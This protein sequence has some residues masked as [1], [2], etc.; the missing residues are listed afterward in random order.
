M[1]NRRHFDLAKLDKVTASNDQKIL[2]A[3]GLNPD[4]Y[5]DIQCACPVH[6]GDNPTGF[7]YDSRIKRW[8]C[9]T[10]KCHEKKEY[11]TGIIGLIRGVR[12]CGFMQAVNWLCDLLGCEIENINE[13]DL[14]TSNYINRRKGN[15]KQKETKIYDKSLLS[16]LNHN[17]DYFLQK[18]FKLE[19]LDHFHCFYCGNKEKALYGRACFPIFNINDDLVGFCGRQT[20]ILANDNSITHYTVKWKYVCDISNHLFNLNNLDAN[21]KTI[22]LVEGIPDVMRL[23]EAGIKNV[24]SSFSCH[25]TLEQRK[26]LI[27][28]GVRNIILLLDPDKAGKEA[29]E[30]LIK[31]NSM[32]F[33]IFDLR[34]LLSDDPGDSTV[35][36]LQE[37]L[38]LEISKIIEQDRMK[39]ETN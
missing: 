19:T 12:K 32:F 14:E 36:I 34:P 7:S 3:L 11:G 2:I 1:E 30:S 26:L 35:E 38:K 17:V 6:G 37:K 24:V 9:W 13:Q 29:S 23:Y 8:R 16:K 10:H 21:E 18:K 27:K 20:P 31:Q 5:G 25:L 33:N 39:Y 4:H 22:C 28:K 15:N